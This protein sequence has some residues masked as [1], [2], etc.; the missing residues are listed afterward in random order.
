MLFYNYLM[1]SL[2]YLQVL[3]RSVHKGMCKKK[4]RQNPGVSKKFYYIEK[5][6]HLLNLWLRVLFSQILQNKVSAK[7]IF[8]AKKFNKFIIVLKIHRF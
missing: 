7:R 3:S 5:N 1:L 2:E 6:L 4:I 8:I